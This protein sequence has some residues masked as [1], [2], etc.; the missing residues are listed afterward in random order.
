[1]MAQLTS[2]DLPLY[3]VDTSQY[4]ILMKVVINEEISQYQETKAI[5]QPYGNL[6]GNQSSESRR[7][8]SQASKIL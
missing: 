7:V 3:E 8:P 4:D 5:K 1:M 2:S 6:S